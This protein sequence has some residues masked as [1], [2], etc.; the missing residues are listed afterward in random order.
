MYFPRSKY[1]GNTDGA[2]FGTTF[3]HLFL[4]SF[5]HIQ[6]SKQSDTYEPRIFGFKVTSMIDDCVKT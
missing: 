4:M 1:Q 3:P 5:R 6:I 2:Y